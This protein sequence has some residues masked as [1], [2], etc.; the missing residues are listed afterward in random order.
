MHPIAKRQRL[1]VLIGVLG[2]FTLMAFVS[3]GA[4]ILRGDPD[5]AQSV[6]LLLFTVLFGLAILARRRI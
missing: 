1:E 2:F 3:A 6:V 5:V 4:S